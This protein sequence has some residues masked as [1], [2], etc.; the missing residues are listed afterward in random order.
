LTR[1]IPDKAIEAS[2][3]LY[4][5]RIQDIVEYKPGAQLVINPILETELVRG[6]GTAYGAEILLEKKQGRLNGWASYT[7]SRSFSQVEET[8]NQEAINEGRRFANDFDKPHDVTF[9]LN[10]QA[11]RRVNVALNFNYSTGRPTSL[12]SSRY[13]FDGITVAHFPERNNARIPDYHRLDLSV[14]LASSLYRE[15]KVEASWTLGIYNVYGRNNAYSVFFDRG[16]G[17]P[18]QAF[19]LAVIGTPLPSLTYNFKF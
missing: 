16:Q 9:A 12:P 8:E 6:T 10:Y 4:Y 5:K 17:Q 3:E 15:K 18:L 7:Y 11:S 1:S 19:Q 2:V 14:T 13:E